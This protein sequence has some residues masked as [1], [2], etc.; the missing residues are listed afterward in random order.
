MRPN[1]V[2][3]EELIDPKVKEDSFNLSNEADLIIAIGTSL[4]VY[5]FAGLAYSC[6]M[7]DMITKLVIVNLSETCRDNYSDIKYE[8]DAIEVFQEIKELMIKDGV[9]FSNHEWM[10]K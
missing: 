10:Q 7:P 6:D 1:I 5:P 2:L 9:D 4:E 8:V 3:Y